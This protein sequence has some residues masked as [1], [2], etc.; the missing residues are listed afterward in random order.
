MYCIIIFWFYQHLARIYHSY[1]SIQ[2]IKMLGLGC[3]GKGCYTTKLDQCFLAFFMQWLNLNFS[4]CMVSLFVICGFFQISFDTPR[5]M[6]HLFFHLS[7]YV[8]CFAMFIYW[9]S[10]SLKNFCR[11]FIGSFDGDVASLEIAQ[12]SQKG[13]ECAFL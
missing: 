7:L 12:C 4:N 1:M 3:I 11:F 2:Q 13:L 9:L 8:L 10:Y 6:F 5:L